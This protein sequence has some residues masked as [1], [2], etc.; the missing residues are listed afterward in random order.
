MS[1]PDP[2]AVEELLSRRRALLERVRQGPVAKPTLVEELAVSRST[3]DR[4]VR[5]LEAAR[6]VRR[7]QDGVALTLPGRLALDRYER[8]RELLADLVR[9]TDVLARLPADAALDP[10]LVDG[11]MVVSPERHDPRRPVGQLTTD[12]REAGRIRAF[13]AAYIP[14]AADAY[15][16]SIVAGDLR[17]ELV[18]TPN[19]LDVLVRECADEMERALDAGL[20]LYRAT[21]P[22]SPYCLL[23]A[24][25]DDGTVVG[26]TVSDEESVTGLVRNDTDAA[27]EW[28]ARRFETVR[29]DA[30][31][32]TR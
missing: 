28:A 17:A 18:V 15:F 25:K 8:F 5:E 16:E 3:V 11:A 13:V 1:S 14:E 21:V 7:S 30:E 12:I 26:V 32:I 19:V 20:R 9:S 29:D 6:L 22:D 10:S 2:E 27:V 4:A 23:L 31:R 24:R